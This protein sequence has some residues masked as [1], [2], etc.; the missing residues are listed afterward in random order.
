[1]AG[2]L[3][4]PEA[5]ILTV[6]FHLNFDCFSLSGAIGPGSEFWG[7][8]SEGFRAPSGARLSL[9]PIV[10][11]KFFVALPHCSSGSMG[12]LTRGCLPGGMGGSQEGV[13]PVVGRLTRGCLAGV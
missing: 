5:K 4:F 12:G 10:F 9:I 13:S 8:C 7:R 11:L 1:M 2:L 6:H 3:G